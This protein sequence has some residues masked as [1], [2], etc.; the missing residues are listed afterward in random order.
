MQHRAG[1]RRFL[2]A[3]ELHGGPGSRIGIHFLQRVFEVDDSF[4]H[5]GFAQGADVTLD[6]Q[7]LVDEV[8]GKTR[9]AALEQARDVIRPPTR[10]THEAAAVARQPRQPECGVVAGRRHR[11]F[12]FDAQFRRDPFVGIEC[13]YPVAG[14]QVQHAVFLHAESRPV[15]RAVYFR[16]AFARDGRGIVSAAGI[17]HHDFV[18]PCD[19]LQA[20]AQGCLFVAGNDDY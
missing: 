18:R 8:G 3:L 6:D 14:R 11:P 4:V 10:M 15:R 19:R 13:Q 20:A 1:E 12:D 9:G 16:A 7:P 2:A 17:K 5:Q